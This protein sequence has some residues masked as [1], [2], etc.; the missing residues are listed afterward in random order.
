MFYL[1][2]SSNSIDQYTKSEKAMLIGAVIGLCGVIVALAL[3]IR[4]LHNR[5]L[6]RER[7]NLSREKDNV[8]AVV[9]MAKEVVQTTQ[10]VKATLDANIKSSDRLTTAVDNMHIVIIKAMGDKKKR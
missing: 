9:G 6:E 8:L 5:M 10:E 7:E 1:Q 2:I 4:H 3:Y